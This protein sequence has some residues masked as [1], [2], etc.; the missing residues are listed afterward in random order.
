[1]KITLNPPPFTYHHTFSLYRS[2]SFSYVSVLSRLQ[3]VLS[4][5]FYLLLNTKYKQYRWLNVIFDIYLL[6]M[7]NQGEV[8]YFPD[9]FE[10]ST[11]FLRLQRNSP[12]N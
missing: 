9:G 3:L 2:S 7:K 6:V 5:Q 10:K 8:I 12:E 1:M 11:G 4:Q